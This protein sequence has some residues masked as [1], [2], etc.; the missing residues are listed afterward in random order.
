[1][2]QV[3]MVTL[4]VLIGCGL[5]GC[6]KS[7]DD[8]TPS[9]K[10]ATT[11]EFRKL[12]EQYSDRFH[13]KMVGSAETVTPAQIYAEASRIWDEVFAGHQDVLDARVQEILDDLDD[14][15]PLD[16]AQYVKVREGERPE[17]A[18][19]EA[20]AT[21]AKQLFWNPVRTAQMGLS[22]WLSQL[23][24]R[25][26][27]ALRRLLISN[28]GL[29]W[30]AADR[31]LNAPVLHLKQG[32]LVFIVALSRQKD[33]YQVEKVRWLRHKAMGPIGIPEEDEE[34]GA[35]PT[36]GQ[37]GAE[38]PATPETGAGEEEGAAETGTGQ[39]AG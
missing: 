27:Y 9:G 10:S 19:D 28:A 20:A 6:Q 29:F 24:R 26:Q 21:T 37:E 12:Y 1:M 2:R 15:E 31:N 11:K 22:R 38:T 39:P 30:K 14:A 33:Y 36:P 35:A 34:G 17:P 16:E 13:E 4:A 7:A 23:L 18:E 32:P 25:E 5:A 8:A 3:L